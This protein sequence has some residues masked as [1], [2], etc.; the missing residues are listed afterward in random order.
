MERHTGIAKLRRKLVEQAYGHVLEAA[1]GTGR[2][3]E[4]YDFDRIKSLT[5]LDQS[6]EMMDVAKAKWQETG[7]PDGECRFYIRSALEPLPLS[8]GSGTQQKD[9]GYDTIIATM[10][11]C[12]TPLPELFLRNLSTGLSY[13]D[14]PVG[15]ASTAL[16]DANKTPPGRILL[17][18]HGRSYYSWLNKFLDRTAPDH[19]LRHGCWWNRDIGQIAKDSGLEIMD[20][21]RQHLGITWWLELGLPDE[22][23]GER[24]QQWLDDTRRR[25]AKS[26]AELEQKQGHVEKEKREEDELRRRDADLEK[27]RRQQRE[28]MKREGS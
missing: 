10:S 26:R 7:P 28:Q 23:K 17:L 3:S 25:I 12:S 20:I 13:R 24:R 18:E 1:A 19:A 5:L 9:G 8:P 14:I 2:N 27:W 6:K 21:R 11:L 22:A 15:S 4:Y 16:S